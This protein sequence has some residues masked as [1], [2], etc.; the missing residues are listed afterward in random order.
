MFYCKMEKKETKAPNRLPYHL[1]VLGRLVTDGQ[2]FRELLGAW[3]GHVGEFVRSKGFVTA[4][5]DI[6][7]LLMGL[8]AMEREGCL[9]RRVP[10]GDLQS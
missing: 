5:G 2:L 6:L 3:I 8:R 4:L 9:W 10:G 7:K 1:M